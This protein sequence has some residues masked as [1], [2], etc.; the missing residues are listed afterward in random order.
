M[1]S[2]ET[3]KSCFKVSNIPA[4][5]MKPGQTTE[6]LTGHPLALAVSRSDRVKPTMANLVAL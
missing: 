1:P 2:D 6:A 3:P 4:P 5:S